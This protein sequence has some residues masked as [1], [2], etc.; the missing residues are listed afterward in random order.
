MALTTIIE[1]ESI[2]WDIAHNG[3]VFLQNQI[4]SGLRTECLV[5]AGRHYTKKGKR[6]A[7]IF[8]DLYFLCYPRR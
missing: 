2:E 4:D 5:N 8:R 1:H 3:P 6:K 7:G